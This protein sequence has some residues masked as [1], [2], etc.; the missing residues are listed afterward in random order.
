MSNDIQTQFL[1]TPERSATWKELVGNITSYHEACKVTLDRCK[2]EIDQNAKVKKWVSEIRP[3]RLTLLT[4]LKL[5]KSIETAGNG[6]RSCGIQGLVFVNERRNR[7][8][9]PLASGYQSVKTN[10]E[11]LIR[12]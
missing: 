8:S 5:A 6:C 7:L 10:N 2:M 4:G 12:R 9:D 3:D 1:K 11:Y